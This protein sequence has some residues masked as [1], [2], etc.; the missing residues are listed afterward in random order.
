MALLLIYLS[1]RARRSTRKLWDEEWGAISTDGNLWSLGSYRR[2][3]EAVMG[4]KFYEWFCKWFSKGG[5]AFIDSFT[6]F[7]A[8]P[9]GHS[10]G[11]GVTYPTNPRFDKQGRWRPRREWPAELR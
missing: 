1:S 9:I 3:W 11:D 10:D 5:L 2:N 8:V 6:F 7:I 4:H